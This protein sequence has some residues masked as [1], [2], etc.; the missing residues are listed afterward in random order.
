MKGTK[1]DFSVWPRTEVFQHFVTDV[2]CLISVTADVDVE[3]MVAFCRQ[4]QLRFFPSFMY[5]V[6]TVVNRRDEF[7]MGYD[8]VGDVVVWDVVHPSYIDFHEQDESITRLISIFSADFERFYTTVTQDMETHKNKRGFEV[9]YDCPNTFDVSCLPWLYYKSL[10]LSVFSPHAYLAPVIT[11]GKYIKRD[12]GLMMPL[13]IRIHHSVA[14]GFHI[15]RFYG[16]IEA[17]LRAFCKK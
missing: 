4:K 17:E 12:E 6:S 11:W 5:V 10:D 1:I 13:S 16:E 14:D 3:S 15:A 9:P 8:E 2:K 7:R